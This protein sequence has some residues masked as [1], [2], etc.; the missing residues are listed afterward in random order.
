MGLME[1]KELSNLKELRR[2]K[3]ATESHILQAFEV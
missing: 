3:D 1:L 2:L